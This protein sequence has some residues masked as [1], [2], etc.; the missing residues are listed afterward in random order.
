MTYELIINP[1]HKTDEEN[2]IHKAAL[3]GDTQALMKAVQD[4][5]TMTAVE[6]FDAVIAAKGNGPVTKAL[7]VWMH[8]QEFHD[9]TEELLFSTMDQLIGNNMFAAADIV[10]RHTDFKPT[11]QLYINALGRGDIGEIGAQLE[12]IRKFG[13]KWSTEVSLTAATMGR[14]GALKW[15]N[16]NHCPFDWDAC[17]HAAIKSQST[18]VMQWMF[19][20]NKIGSQHFD[21]I[22]R[23]SKTQGKAVKAAT[24]A[25]LLTVGYI[26]KSY[27]CLCFPRKR[28]VVV[29]TEPKEPES[30]DEESKEE[31]KTE[32][33][34]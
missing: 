14:V 23:Y 12:H 8:N 20:M 11:Q 25:W 24:L 28:T 2:P 29:T 30:K 19:D 16:E 32:Q 1:V 10:R 22:Y 18:S 26:A 4:K 31:T 33:P 3:A 6:V 13:A 27:W 34:K 21:L 15:L 9:L 17:L 7:M 5:G